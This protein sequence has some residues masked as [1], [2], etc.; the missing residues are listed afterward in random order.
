MKALSF[1]AIV[2]AAFL[3]F[4]GLSSR[5]G[6][7]AVLSNAVIIGGVLIAVVVAGSW[8]AMYFKNRQ[9]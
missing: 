2:I 3:V 9:Q 1:I 7:G 6:A 4:L 5:S 8:I